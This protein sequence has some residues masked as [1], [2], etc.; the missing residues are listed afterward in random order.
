MLLHA[1]SLHP[2]PKVAGMVSRE[3]EAESIVVFDEAHNI[4]RYTAAHRTVATFDTYV[5]AVTS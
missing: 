5:Y 1:I 3:L 2:D 4:D